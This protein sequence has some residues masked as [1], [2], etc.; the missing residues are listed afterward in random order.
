ME[1]DDG[2]KP[3]MDTELAQNPLHVMAYRGGADEQLLGYLGGAPPICHQAQHLLFARRQQSKPI[4]IKP[5]GMACAG[6][7]LRDG[8]QKVYDASRNGLTTR[9]HQHAHSDTGHR[10]T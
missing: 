1:S 7:R 3:A 8:L 9:N 4:G 2:P 5:V 6:R 10:T